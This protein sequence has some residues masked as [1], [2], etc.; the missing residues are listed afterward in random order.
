MYKRQIQVHVKAFLTNP[1]VTVGLEE[2]KLVTVSLLGEVA[3]PGQFALEP[4][5]GVL[6]ALA[7]A[8]GLTDFA[9]RDRIFVLREVDGKP[10]RI[11]F[12][13]QALTEASGRAAE[14][15][16]QSGDVVVVE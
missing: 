3:K 11:R 13:Y 7:A 15:R 10:L 5:A 6:H 14:F 16:V 4:G 12:D 2:A 8:G 9:H 1:V